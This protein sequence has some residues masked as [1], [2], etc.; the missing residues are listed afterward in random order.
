MRQSR[1]LPYLI[2]IPIESDSLLLFSAEV[3]QSH[4]TICAASVFT[5]IGLAFIYSRIDYCN[6]HLQ[7]S[8][9][10]VFPEDVS[11]SW[12]FCTECASG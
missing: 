5:S 9:S 4:Q 11:T 10:Y 1:L 7:S 3:A 2:W 12:G 8:L 6:S